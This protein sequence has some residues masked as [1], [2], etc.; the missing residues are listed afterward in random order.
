MRKRVPS[1]LQ[2]ESSE[3]GLACLAMIASY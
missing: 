3:C 1:I 2:S